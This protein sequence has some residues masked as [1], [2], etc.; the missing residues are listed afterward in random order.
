MKLDS[1]SFCPLILNRLLTSNKPSTYRGPRYCLCFSRALLTST[2]CSISMK[3]RPVGLPS[4]S[5]VRWIPLTPLRTLHSEAH[6]EKRGALET[7]ENINI[8]LLT[9]FTELQLEMFLNYEPSL[10]FQVCIKVS[11]SVQYSNK[12]LP[13]IGLYP[14]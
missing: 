8:K 5:T 13:I 11:D 4:L 14:L 6:Q 12:M 3:A 7:R 2:T 10:Y 9:T 1:A